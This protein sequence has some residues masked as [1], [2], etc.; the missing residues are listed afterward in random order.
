MAAAG[1]RYTKDAARRLGYASGLEV[2]TS[3]QL[4]QAGVE[5][6]YESDQCK[7]DYTTNVRKG[8]VITK[9]GMNYE[10][11]TGCKVIQWHEY[12][13]DFMITKSNGQPMFIETKGYFK[14]KDRTKH[15]DLKKRYPDLDLRIIFSSNGKVSPKTTYSQWAEKQGI[16]YHCLSYGEKKAGLIVPKSWLEE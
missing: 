6:E 1:N 9:D 10:L 11:P 15:Q 16:R 12:T 3:E 8:G 5:F 13:C 7:F 14:A 2:V 4:Q